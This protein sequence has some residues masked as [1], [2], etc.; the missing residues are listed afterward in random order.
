MSETA[1][2]GGTIASMRGAARPRI[3]AE[4]GQCGLIRNGGVL[5]RGGRIAAVGERSVV[6]KALGPEARVVELE[7]RLVTPGLVDAHTHAVFAGNR[8]DEFESLCSG[9][10]YAEIA[11]AGGGIRSTVRAVRNA[12]EDALLEQSVRH[13][14]W[15]LACGTT[16]AEI[17]SGYG[18]DAENETKMLR[19][20]GKLTSLTGL[21]VTRTFLG[22]HALPAEFEGKKSEYLGVMLDQVLPD[23]VRQ[24]LASTADMFVETRYFDAADAR[25]LASACARLGVDLRLH[26]DQLHDGGGAALAAEL[27]ARTADHLE[28]TEES[29]IRALAEA[30]VVPVLLPTSVFGLRM[31]RYPRARAMV[32]L[33]LPIVIATDFNPGSAPSP[34]LPFAMG[35]ACRFMR[36]TPSEALVACTINAAHALRLDAEVGSLETGKSADAV[37]WDLEAIE[38]LPYWIGAPWIRAVYAGGRRVVPG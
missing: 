8:A 26:V 31:E 2:L 15:M 19:V 32:D 12:S 27:G 36:L 3:G 22:A 21:R 7:G 10:T 24:G 20:A 18:L 16:T 9:K 17:K 33:G 30:G 4:L 14:R 35:L 25:R 1:L 11:Q 28:Q 29:G 13:A 34:S 38:E 37:V 23:L 5:F 6:E